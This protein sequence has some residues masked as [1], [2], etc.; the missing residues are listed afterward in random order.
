[1]NDNQ[2]H[3]ITI[4]YIILMFLIAM[5]FS[6]CFEFFNNMGWIKYG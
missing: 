2:E 6:G 5:Y 1:M 3:I 4:A